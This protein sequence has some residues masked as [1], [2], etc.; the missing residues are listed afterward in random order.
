MTVGEDDIPDT[1][2]SFAS[3]FSREFSFS[4]ADGAPPD[5]YNVEPDR[6][7][8]TFTETIAGAASHLSATVTGDL[9]LTRQIALPSSWEP[10]L[11]PSAK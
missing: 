10:T 8:G 6:I 9:V 2:T 1:V 4:A 7:I 5:D 3:A 11:E